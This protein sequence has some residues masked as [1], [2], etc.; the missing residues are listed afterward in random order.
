MASIGGGFALLLLVVLSFSSSSVNV[1]ANIFQLGQNGYGAAG[2]LRGGY[3][4][5][6]CPL[7]EIIV[8]EVVSKAVAANPG[9]APGLGCDGSVLIDSTPN[10][11]AEKEAPPNNPSLRGFEVI[12]SA[13]A[14]LEQVCEGVVSCA[15]ILAFAARD[16]IALTRG[17]YYDVPGGRRDGRISRASETISLPPPTSNL[18]HLTQ[19]F[20][21]K[22]LSQQEMVFLSGAHTIGRS[23]CS[24]FSNRLYN[25]NSTVSQDPSLDPVYAAQLKKECPRNSSASQTVFMDPRTPNVFD[26]NYYKDI[27]VQRG[28]FTSDMALLSSPSTAALVRSNAKNWLLFQENFVAAIIKMGKIGVLTGNQGEIRLNCSRIN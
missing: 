20:A 6:T 4:W 23:H 24:S 1:E 22:G 28:L 8:K 16:S 11:V 9:F 13:K 27:L 18:S 25:F 2:K 15:D 26:T 19:S 3:Y 21:V 10:N 12:A 7:A 17:L 5:N 14:L